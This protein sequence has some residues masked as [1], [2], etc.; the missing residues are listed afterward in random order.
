MDN[1]ILQNIRQTSTCFEGTP[2]ASNCHRFAFFRSKSGS[3]QTCRLYIFIE[4]QSSCQLQND[5]VI[6]HV[7][8]VKFGILVADR[9]GDGACLN[10]C[11]SI[12]NCSTAEMVTARRTVPKGNLPRNSGSS[13]SC[14]KSQESQNNKS[15]HVD[16]EV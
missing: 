13:V 5:D 2:A 12:Q 10:S 8:L 11:I 3:R 4:L 16:K 1:D 14:C 6:I 9:L 7:F 15:L